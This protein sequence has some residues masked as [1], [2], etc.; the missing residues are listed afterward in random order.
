MDADASCC[1]PN[2]HGQLNLLCS[3]TDPTTARELE[4]GIRRQ[5]IDPHIPRSV[6]EQDR[7][8]ARQS[9]WLALLEA[10]AR[11]DASRG[12]T[13]ST[14]AYWPIRSA[15]ADSRQQTICEYLEEVYDPRGLSETSD[16]DAD[17]H[18]DERV[19]AA[20]DSP[21][22][23]VERVERSAYVRSFVAQLA[24]PTQQLVSDVFW[25]GYTAAEVARTLGRSRQAVSKTLAR[26]YDQ[27]RRQ[28]GKQVLTGDAA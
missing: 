9:A 2:L 16:G 20:D 28:L 4:L 10:N 25:D 12:A 14:F 5:F 3:T 19:A 15:V 7:E 1:V 21:L 18:W 8:D 23:I 11:Y 17:A 27:G 22:E 13:L 26:V 6:A 24:G